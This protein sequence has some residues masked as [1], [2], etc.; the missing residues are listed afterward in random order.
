MKLMKEELRNYRQRLERWHP[1]LQMRRVCQDILDVGD[2]DQPELEFVNKAWAAA[3]FVEQRRADAVRL[4]PANDQSDFE[5]QFGNRKEQWK[6]APAEGLN[7]RC[8]SVTSA[9]HFAVAERGLQD[10]PV[11]AWIARAETAPEAM[12]AQCAATA[13]RHYSGWVRLLVYLEVQEYGIR[14]REIEASFPSATAPAKDA[15][16]EVWVFWKERAYCVWKDGRL[17][18]EF[19]LGPA[20]SERQLAYVSL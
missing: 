7:P 2:A 6:F 9:C 20:H 14:Q 13:A 5:L 17:A 10:D 12:R 15:F 19:G 8:G 16:S 11:S 4:I 1:P 3:S 18:L